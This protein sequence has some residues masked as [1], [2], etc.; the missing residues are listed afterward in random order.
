MIYNEYEIEECNNNDV[1]DPL[2]TSNIS[3]S[4]TFTDNIGPYSISSNS[5]LQSISSINDFDDD[6]F[7]NDI[8][9][10]NKIINNN[11]NEDVTYI[12]NEFCLFNY[13][14]FNIN[15]YYHEK[16][17]TLENVSLMYNISNI[18]IIELDYSLNLNMKM[19]LHIAGFYGFQ[20]IK[21]MKKD[22]LIKNLVLYETNPINHNNVIQRLK[23]FHYIDLL[24][25]NN[26]LR[27]FIMIP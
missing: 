21:K 25:Q 18:N 19:L 15:N 16:K 17:F 8:I 6:L 13:D 2:S 22:E 5:S 23:L 11:R 12:D 7:I 24:K 26:Y 27:P 9:T 10:E 4:T 1:I 3:I 20:K 14:D